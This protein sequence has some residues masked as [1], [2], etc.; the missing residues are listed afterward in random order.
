MR[1]PRFAN[2]AWLGL[3]CGF[4]AL[5]RAELILMVPFLAVPAAVLAR[6]PTRAVRVRLLALT[7]AVCIVTVSPWVVRNLVTFREPTF[8]STGDGA[9]LGSSCDKTY[10]GNEIGLWNFDCAVQA[11][12]ARDPSVASANQ[13]KAAFKYIGN[14]LGRLPVVMAV[15]VLRIWDLYRPFQGARYAETEGRNIVVGWV[16]LVVHWLFIVLGFIGFFAMKRRGLT[17]WPLV[18]PIVFI[19]LLASMTQGAIRYR[20]P[21]EVAVVLLGSFG[22]QAVWSWWQLR[23][24]GGDPDG[25]AL[26]EASAP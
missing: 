5:S 9:I 10:Y 18:M 20:A 14:H 7:M 15:R 4:G 19:T 25:R 17:R 26:S 2:A 24:A 21:A 16:G 8:L 1:D 22:L 11:E 13:R 23:R 6:G 3:V 12:P